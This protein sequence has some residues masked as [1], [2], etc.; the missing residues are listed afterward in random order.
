MRFPLIAATVVALLLTACNGPAK[1]TPETGPE[2]TLVETPEYTGVII[3]ENGSSEFSYLFDSASTAFWEPSIDDMQEL[4][5]VS[6]NTLFLY[7]MTHNLIPIS[8]Q[9]LHSS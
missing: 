7:K 9:I 6:D 2:N 4:K 3:S 8:K 5:S 1:S